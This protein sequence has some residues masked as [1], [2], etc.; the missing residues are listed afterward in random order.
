MEKTELFNR[1]QEAAEARGINPAELSMDEIARATGVSRSSLYRRFG[2]RQQ[3]SAEMEAS[4]L[5]VGSR[6]SAHDRLITAA[7]AVI[8][9]QGIQALTLEAVAERAEVAQP[10]VYTL[11][12]NRARLMR[13]VFTHFSPIPRVAE[14]L[15]GDFPDNAVE[16][17]HMIERAYREIWDFLDEQQPLIFAIVAEVARNP[18]SVVMGWLREEYLPQVVGIILPIFVRAMG[19]GLIEPAHPATTAQMFVGPMM[20]HCLSRPF[21]TAAGVPLPNRDDVCADFARRFCRAVLVEG[22]R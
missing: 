9:E 22:S 2:S 3:L 1:I 6:M 20:L 21:L 7:H 17:Q 5:Q 19:Q 18:E 10:T 4:G 16:F 8:I 13:T 11:F 12:G 15:P 14:V